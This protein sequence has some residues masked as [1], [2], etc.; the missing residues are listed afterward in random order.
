M[1]V[2]LVNSCR[3]S[4]GVT[5]IECIAYIGVLAV[6]MSSGSYAISKAWRAS[7]EMSR[8]SQD[9][10]SALSAGE[11]WRADIRSARG[12]IRIEN[13][14]RPEAV[15]IIPT[16]EGVVM[17]Q[18]TNGTLLRRAAPQAPWVVVLKRATNSNMHSLSIHGVEAWRWELEMLSSR[19]N[20]GVRPLFTFTAVPEGGSTP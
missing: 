20:A 8:N 6:L 9:I 16:G 5:L 10:Q 17:Y 12:E 11:H 4:S 2:P 7:R 3:R 14:T 19:K 18:H 13:A 1:K 15:L